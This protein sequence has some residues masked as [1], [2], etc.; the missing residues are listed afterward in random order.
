M[1]KI[2]QK[3]IINVEDDETRIALIHGKSLNNLYIEQTH[4]TQKIGNIYCGKVVKVQPSFQAAFI[5][6]GEERHGFLSLSDI[7]FQVYK[8]NREIR[9]RLSITQL[10]KPGQK[11]LVQLVKDEIAHKGASLTTNIS[12]AGRFLV[13]MPDSERGGVSRK[14]EDE[15]QRSRLRHLLKGLGGEDSSAII[16]TVGVDRS[17]TELKRD[18]MIL[19]RTWNEIKEEYEEQSA[20]GLLYQE[21]NAMVRMIR[22]YYHED[23]SEVVIDEP[24]AFQRAL[25]F[26]QAHMP[27]EQKKLQLFLGEKSLFSSYDIEGQIEALHNQ[28]VSLPS[29][30]SLVIIPTEALVAIDVNSGRS[31]QERNIEATALRTNLEAAEEVAK[32]LRLRNLGGLIVVDF[33]DMDNSKN[34]LSVEQKIEEAMSADKAKTSF[35][36]ISKF[37]LLELSRQRISGSLSRNSVVVTLANRI[38]RKIHDSAVEK[39]VLQVHI[40]L[41]LEISS[42]LLN[43]K[44][45]RLTQMEMDF[46]IRISI[47]PDTSLSAEEIPEMEVALREQDGGET[48]ASVLISASDM[49]DENID[50]KKRKGNNDVDKIDKT[51]LVP[52]SMEMEIEEKQTRQIK[53]KNPKLS[54]QSK[55]KSPL[56]KSSSKQDQNDL[57]SILEKNNDELTAT[58]KQETPEVEKKEKTVIKKQDS[59]ENI[60]VELFKSVHE[61]LE[62]DDAHNEKESGQEKVV[63]EE[64]VSEVSTFRSFHL[65]EN[66]DSV[67]NTKII[68][69]DY[70]TIDTIE[71]P[72]FSSVHITDTVKSAPEIDSSKQEE[73]SRWAS[74]KPKSDSAKKSGKITQGESTSKTAKEKLNS[75]KVDIKS[76]TRKTMIESKAVPVTKVK[77]KSK[78]VSV[79]KIGTDNS[80]TS[81]SFK[82]KKM[83]ASKPNQD[84]KSKKNN[85]IVQKHQKSEKTSDESL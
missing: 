85:K 43:V 47:T 1:S 61:P 81:R 31:M 65:D 2:N 27:K 78:N 72:M 52:D 23:I 30:G 37:G 6:Y 32:Q 3:I 54:S 71:T 51:S 59:K 20:I 48:R 15:D 7:N 53:N 80:K 56:S 28:Q 25:E 46:G 70:P 83:S 57:D 60:N 11:V 74:G 34:R 77:L 67:E 13:F 75:K 73:E 19:R 66:L 45:Q 69:R 49:R 39:K 62:V 16:R 26:F 42:H 82:I 64:T 36:E 41:P 18:F 8:P 33:I 35:G 12:L 4:Q 38:L 22:D 44:R 63:D 68:S 79:K 58:E 17:L 84:S 10:L 5:D 21:E 40:R 29:G 9:G 50:V 55:I 14:I 76:K 24:V